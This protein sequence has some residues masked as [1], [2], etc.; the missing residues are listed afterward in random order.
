M[1][2]GLAAVILAAGE[3]TRMRSGLPKMLHPIAGLPMVSY[4]VRLSA[5]LGA[6]P[7][8]L[9]VG[10]GAEAVL[11]AGKAAVGNG[12]A[13]I[14]SALQTQR[15]GTAHAVMAGLEKLGRFRG[16]VLILYGDVPNL[17][18]AT[19]KRMLARARR[20]GEPLVLLT[21]RVPDPFGYGRVL[22]DEDGMPL[23]IVEEKDA[24]AAERQ[25][26]EINVGTYLVDAGLLRRGL[27]QVDDRNRKREFYLTDLV[28]LARLEG[29]DVGAVVSEDPTEVAGINDRLQLAQAEVRAQDALLVKLMRSG[30]TLSDPATL[31]IDAD[32]R[33]GRETW[34]GPGVVLQGKTRIG[35]GCCIDAHVVIRDSVVGRGAE[36][37]AGAV[38]QGTRVAAG[39]VVG[40]LV[41][42]P[43]GS[44]VRGRR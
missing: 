8:V 23:R 36:I 22:R 3:G 28:E 13:V 11:A 16:R 17:R 7:V 30:V 35:A 1:T 40:P 24:T 34:L 6:K 20:R 14:R 33:V 10:C 26:D 31:H 4:P 9:V 25:I 42:L 44:R 15:L 5:G 41:H 43:P 29:A 21:C 12:Q 18:P 32:V 19:V 37:G 38:L 2:Q 39:A 27:V